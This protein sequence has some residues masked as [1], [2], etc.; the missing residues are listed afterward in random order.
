MRKH[1]TVSIL[2]SNSLFSTLPTA[3]LERVAQAASKHQYAKGT[4]L[5]SQGDRGDAFFGIVAGRIRISASAANGQEVHLIELGPG[6]TFG[7]IALIHGGLRTATAVASSRTTAMVIERTH[8]LTI[9]DSEPKLVFQLLVRLCER[10]RWTSELVED[11]SFLDVPAQIAKRVWLLA[12]SFGTPVS[13]SIELRISQA[14]L[15]AFL[16]VSRQT[17]NTH[18]QSW[19]QAGSIDLSRGRILIRDLDYLKRLFTEIS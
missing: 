1:T 15:A 9:L 19:Q 3:A 4:L 18:L 14:D 2:Q 10:V 16:G 5:F 11:L 7:E 17:V 6:D 12:Q 13:E 8:F